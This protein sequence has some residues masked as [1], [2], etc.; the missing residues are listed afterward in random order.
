MVHLTFNKLQ[1]RN[2][3][4]GSIS[5][6]YPNSIKKDMSCIKNRRSHIVPEVQSH[7]SPQLMK[8][9]VTFSRPSTSLFYV[10]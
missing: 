9:S 5:L 8:T 6:F 2:T 1:E 4:E 7:P 10:G 3:L